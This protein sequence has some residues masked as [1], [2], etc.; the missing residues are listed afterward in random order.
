MSLRSS[1][2]Y[3]YVRHRFGGSSSRLSSCWSPQTGRTIEVTI[4]LY[5]HIKYTVQYSLD[6]RMVHILL[7][8]SGNR[9]NNLH[10]KSSLTL[11]PGL[12]DQSSLTTGP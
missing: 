3:W 6:V 12:I 5:Q 11:L 10:R 2:Y 4:S 1:F 9:V 7:Y 8:I